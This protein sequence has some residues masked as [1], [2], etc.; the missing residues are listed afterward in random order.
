MNGFT[1]IDTVFDLGDIQTLQETAQETYISSIPVWEPIPNPGVNER[2]DITD[3][4]VMST[5]GETAVPLATLTGGTDATATLVTISLNTA[6]TNWYI[7]AGKMIRVQDILTPLHVT[8]IFGGGDIVSVNHPSDTEDYSRAFHLQG[9]VVFDGIHFHVDEKNPYIGGLY[10]CHLMWRRFNYSD[11]CELRNCIF[12]G[13]DSQGNTRTSDLLKV[14]TDW[15]GI[16]RHE[17]IKIYNNN[18]VQAGHF[19]MEIGDNLPEEL[20][21]EDMDNVRGLEIFNNYFDGRNQTSYYQGISMVRIR[22]KSAIKIYNN[23]FEDCDW[24]IELAT[25]DGSSV[26]NNEIIGSS[27]Y[28]IIANGSH[29][30]ALY[31]DDKVNT[32]QNFVYDNHIVAGS[33]NTAEYPFVYMY[34]GNRDKWSNN[35]VDSRVKFSFTDGDLANDLYYGGDWQDN[36]IIDQLDT[37]GYVVTWDSSIVLN[38]MGITFKNNDVY[39]LRTSDQDG[40]R[41][42]PGS[43]IVELSGNDIQLLNG[44]ECITD[45]FAQIGG[46]CNLSWDGVTPPLPVGLTGAGLSDP[47]NIGPIGTKIFDIDFSRATIGAYTADMQEADFQNY[48]GES[49]HYLN[50]DGSSM[51][52]DSSDLWENRV[53]IVDDGTENVLDV[54]YTANEF[55]Y[56]TASGFLQVCALPKVGR[57]VENVN[58]PTEITLMYSLKFVGGV[59]WGYGGKL[60]GLA[61]GLIPSGGIPVSDKYDLYN[62]FSAR[63]MWE[64]LWGVSGKPTG[65]RPY[66]Y[67]I[68]LTSG[69]PLYGRG[70]YLNPVTPPT[71]QFDTTDN[72]PDSFQPSENIWYKI[73]Q[74]IIPN[75]PGNTDGI[76]KIWLNEELMV[77]LVGVKYVADGYDGDYTVDRL[78]FST[79]YG[80]GDSAWAPTVDS[81]IRFKD[82]NIYEKVL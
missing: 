36:V 54:L 76:M 81:H 60:P 74:T 44:V 75:T 5:Y 65:L 48:D 52:G 6:I 77:D 23:K 79:F 28:P 37:S 19:A 1:K 34:Y 16:M 69:D 72:N 17:N 78:C 47:T 66:I 82:F 42:A 11:K 25:N 13:K 46:S 4:T 50:H 41:M 58:N 26:Y 40:L 20:Q 59:D 31:S 8:H 3:Q 45:G 9:T 7:P 39:G 30:S 43:S 27:Q 22:K 49:L 51:I 71:S 24:G 10:G 57:P 62:G 64:D 68:Q 14:L 32:G 29:N 61:G 12:E 15:D 55:G 73:T 80:G 21:H 56:G 67:N 38:P 18:F 63:F 2:I 33:D 70:P 53:S 35:F